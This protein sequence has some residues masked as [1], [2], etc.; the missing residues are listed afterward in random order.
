MYENTILD[1]KDIDISKFIHE[2]EHPMIIKNLVNSSQ[3][4]QSTN[5]F[6]YKV[7]SGLILLNAATLYYYNSKI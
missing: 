4:W 5:N 3:L 2:G 6:L 1:E 7:V